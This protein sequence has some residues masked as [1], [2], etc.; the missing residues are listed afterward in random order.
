MN[1][2]SFMLIC[3]FQVIP[4]LN[5]TIGY[6]SGSWPYSMQALCDFSLLLQGSETSAS[7]TGVPTVR[8]TLA[9]ARREEDKTKSGLFKGTGHLGLLGQEERAKHI[10]LPEMTGREGNFNPEKREGNFNP[11]K[12]RGTRD[13]LKEMVP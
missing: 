9:L 8:A 5:V 11:E 1:A 6:P 4:V 13:N 3:E 12:K 2:A 7:S 10:Q